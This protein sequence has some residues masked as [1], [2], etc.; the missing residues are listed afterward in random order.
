MTFYGELIGE[1]SSDRKFFHKKNVLMPALDQFIF[2]KMAKQ[3]L[4]T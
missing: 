3:K 1:V 4:I 2:K